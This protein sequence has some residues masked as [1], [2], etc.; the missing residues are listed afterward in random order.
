MIQIVE[1]VPH[2]PGPWIP[3]KGD[4]DD[5]NRWLILSESEPHYVIATIENGQP[6]DCLKTEAATARLVAASPALF[7]LVKAVIQ[8]GCMPQGWERAAREM[9][10]EIE[11][12]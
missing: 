1:N 2:T 8:F 9:I 3:S 4:E 12:I 7:D 5:E 10:S 11:G 6:G